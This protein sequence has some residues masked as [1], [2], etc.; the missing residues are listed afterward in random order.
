MILV[1]GAAGKTG[2]AVIES[3]VS[4]GFETRAMLHRPEHEEKVRLAGATEIIFG[5]LESEEDVAEAFM[6]AKKVYFIVP[7]LQLSTT[8]SFI[9]CCSH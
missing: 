2:L 4:K 1:T 3:L 6:G 5:D 9:Y 7:N 8:I